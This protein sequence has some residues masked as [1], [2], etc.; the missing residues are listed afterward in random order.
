MAPAKKTMQPIFR[1]HPLDA[2][3]IHAL[4][5]YFEAGPSQSEAEASVNR[6]AFLLISLAIAAGVIFGFDVLWKGRFYHSS[7]SGGSHCG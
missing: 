2:E 1:G 4:A 3:E 7:L 6:I 5:A